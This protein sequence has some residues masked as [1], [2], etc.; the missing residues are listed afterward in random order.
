[1]AHVKKWENCRR[2]LKRARSAIRAK[3][4]NSATS[5]TSDRR[6]PIEAS[7]NQRKTRRWPHCLHRAS[8]HTRS[9]SRISTKLCSSSSSSHIHDLICRKTFLRPLASQAQWLQDPYR[10]NT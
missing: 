9:R 7:D 5:E 10:C 1:M 2:S 4:G 8:R 3:R 6:H